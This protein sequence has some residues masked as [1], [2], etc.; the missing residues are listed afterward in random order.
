MAIEAAQ[1]EPSPRELVQHERYRLALKHLGLDPNDPAALTLVLI[2]H[3]YNL[4]P[5]LKHVVLIP[6]K[7][8]T[9]RITRRDVYITRDGLLHVAHM[10]GQ[11]SGIVLEKL[12]ETETS[13]IAWVAVYRQG[14]EHPFRYF[15]EYPKDPPQKHMARYAR[16]MAVKCAE[17]MALR[18]AFDVA[19]PVFEERWEVHTVENMEELT[20]EFLVRNGDAPTPRES[21]VSHVTEVTAEQTEDEPAPPDVEHE[22]P[23]PPEAEPEEE[24]QGQGVLPGLDVT[25]ARTQ[26]IDFSNALPRSLR[27]K[28]FRVLR[29]NSIKLAQ[30]DE[31]SLRLFAELAAEFILDHKADLPPQLVEPIEQGKSVWDLSVEPIEEDE[32]PVG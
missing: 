5:L 25:T 19:A 17:A 1:V 26:A 2:A 10:S 28:F 12:E 16:H 21:E 11:L 18:R 6:Q 30:L 22:E 32:I 29:E 7:D 9:G 31:E 3:R 23:E 15:G 27:T 24:P 14:C 4:D 8:R 20:P 13:W